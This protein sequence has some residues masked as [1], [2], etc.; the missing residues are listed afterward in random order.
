MAVVSVGA[1]STL[2]AGSTAE[3]DVDEAAK[4]KHKTY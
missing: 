3:A 1:A 2:V 4:A